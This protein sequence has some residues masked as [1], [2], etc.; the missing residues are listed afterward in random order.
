[1]STP[2]HSGCFGLPVD[3]PV[4]A[5]DDGHGAGAAG[6]HLARVAGDAPGL[7]EAIYGL[8]CVRGNRQASGWRRRARPRLLSC[9][10][11]H[12]LRAAMRP[13]SQCPIASCLVMRQSRACVQPC[14]RSSC[15]RAPQDTAGAAVSVGG[16]SGQAR[17]PERRL[18]RHREA[19]SGT[20]GLVRR[21]AAADVQALRG[22]PRGV[23][24]S[25]RGCHAL[26]RCLWQ[27]L[28]GARQAPAAPLDAGTCPVVARR[29]GLLSF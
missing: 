22:H 21:G 2:R 7:H 4:C 17:R 3:R 23:P 26:R 18:K 19:P 29:W 15:I 5:E 24:F 14:M 25:R 10:T 1:M 16:R 27:A 12:F 8:S 28:E 20:P 13:W 11:V 6:L 9:T